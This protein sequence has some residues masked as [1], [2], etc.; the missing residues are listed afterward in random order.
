MNKRERLEK[1]RNVLVH[2]RESRENCVILPS[3]ENDNKLLP[4]LCLIR[5]I[6]ETI[7]FRYNQPLK[8]AI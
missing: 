7:A 5:R 6:A 8:A 4:Y 2:A 3:E 1:I